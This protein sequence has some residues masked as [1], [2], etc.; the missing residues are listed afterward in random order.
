MRWGLRPCLDVYAF[1]CLGGYPCRGVSHTPYR[2]PR[3]GANT[4]PRA[5]IRSGPWGPFGGRIQYAP[6]RVRAFVT[7][8]RPLSGASGG[9]MPL[10]PGGSPPRGSPPRVSPP[11]VSPWAMVRRAYSPAGYVPFGPCS[12]FGGRMPLRPGVSPPR[13]SPWAMVHRAY[14]PA[15][16]V[17]FGPG[18]PFGLLVR[19]PVRP[20][21]APDHSPG[22]NPGR[23]GYVPFGPCGP[24][25]LLVRV[26][27]RP[28][29]APDHSPGRNPG[30]A[31]YVHSPRWGVEMLGPA[32]L[33][34]CWGLRPCW[35][36]GACGPL[37][38]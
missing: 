9:R 8:I 23:A 38:C 6:T 26:P 16:Y 12:P 32:A 4:R 3:H 2:A 18:G 33:L 25:G 36:V 28:V 20:V 14:S 37:V 21:G 5:F 13:V 19:A 35:F 1:R 27:V 15:G 22:R 31:G 11:R 17:P 29:G 7:C 34:R 10:R 24:F 30:R